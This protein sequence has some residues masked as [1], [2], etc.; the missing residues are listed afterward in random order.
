M[1]PSL[2]KSFSSSPLWCTGVSFHHK[3]K[4]GRLTGIQDVGT[5]DKFTLEVELRNCRPIAVLLDTLT[6][7]IVG[8]A[9]ERLE[10]RALNAL[11]MSSTQ[12]SN[13]LTHVDVKNLDDSPR[14][15]ALGGIRRSLHE[16]DERVL[17]NGLYVQ[18][19]KF[20]TD[21]YTPTSSMSLRASAERN[22]REKAAEEARVEGGRER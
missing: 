15:T 10:L 18:H 7:L 4:S 14:E 2:T 6:K 21:P 1:M 13:M 3:G 16:Q 11:E 9:V 22:R 19:R 17:V 5:T 20:A 12:R 8:Q